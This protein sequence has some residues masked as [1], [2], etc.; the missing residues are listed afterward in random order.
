MTAPSWKARTVFVICCFSALGSYRPLS[1]QTFTRRSELPPLRLNYHDLTNIIGR[2][3]QL[4]TTANSSF[5]NDGLH[6]SSWLDLEDG[7]TQLEFPQKE[8]T[9]L[10]LESVP[11]VSTEVRY[12]YMYDGAPIS[13]VTIDLGD[14]SRQITVEG[15][16]RT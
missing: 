13:G 8:I 7:Q 9:V 5:S 11:Q 15:A 6:P 16:S 4:V 2:G 10:G 12:V 3:Y 14:Y 1:A